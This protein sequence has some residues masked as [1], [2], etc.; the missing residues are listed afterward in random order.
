MQI[1]HANRKPVQRPEQMSFGDGFVRG[2][3]LRHQL[4]FR[5]QRDNRVDLRID[6][7]D[8]FQMRLHHFARGNLFV[9]DRPGQVSGPHETDFVFRGGWH[10]C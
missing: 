7:R 1:L 3:R 8:L 6:A 9:T 5:N 2:Q 4:F 10:D